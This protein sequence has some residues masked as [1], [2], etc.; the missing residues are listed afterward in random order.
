MWA[1]NV[2]GV[3]NTIRTAMG[4]LM[5]GGLSSSVLILRTDAFRRAACWMAATKGAVV[6]PGDAA[7]LRT[8][9]AINHR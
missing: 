4:S 3:I 6:M 2:Q 1:V 7:I 9:H 5:A 8:A